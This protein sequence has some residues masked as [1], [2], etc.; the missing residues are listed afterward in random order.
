MTSQQQTIFKCK[1]CFQKGGL[2]YFKCPKCRIRFLLN[3]TCKKY[4][5]TWAEIIGKKW[6]DVGDWK[7]EPSCGCQGECKRLKAIR[8]VPR[9]ETHSTFS[10]KRKPL[11]FK[12]SFWSD[13]N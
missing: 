13:K 6:G 8:N 1:G 4:R 12:T 11:P 2:Y 7:Q 3:E 9:I 5:A 10:T